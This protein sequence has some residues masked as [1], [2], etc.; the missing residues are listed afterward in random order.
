MTRQLPVPMTYGVRTQSGDPL[1]ELLSNRYFTEWQQ[2]RFDRHSVKSATDA[3]RPDFTQPTMTRAAMLRQRLLPVDA[4]YPS[5]LQPQAHQLPW[6]LARFERS[7]RPQLDTFRSERARQAAVAAWRAEQSHRQGPVGLGI[8]A[9]S[10][11]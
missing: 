6:R 1:H 7:A 11:R 2:S 5:A 3:V 9:A 4:S 10:R 8:Y